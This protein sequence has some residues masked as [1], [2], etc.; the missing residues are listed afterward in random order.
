MWA[1]LPFLFFIFW[2]KENFVNRNLQVAFR[3]STT[4]FVSQ[5]QYQNQTTGLFVFNMTGDTILSPSRRRHPILQLDVPFYAYS[6][7]LDWSNLAIQTDDFMESYRGAKH[8]DD[9]WFLV[10]ALKHPMRT[11]KPNSFSFP[12]C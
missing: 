3:N 11:T 1:S 8:A 9:F 7:E 12:R 10:N 4:M 6:N 2:S 5:Q